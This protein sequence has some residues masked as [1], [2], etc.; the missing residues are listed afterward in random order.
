LGWDKIYHFL[1]NQKHI[2]WQEEKEA[3][4]A[5]LKNNPPV[6]TKKSNSQLITLL[7]K[8]SVI[9]SESIPFAPLMSLKA[10][11]PHLAHR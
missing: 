2:L 9:G 7:T 6:E 8:I 4:Q 11:I 1:F 5:N 10:G 3:D